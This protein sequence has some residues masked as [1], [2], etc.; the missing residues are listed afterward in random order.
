M[1]ALLIQPPV[2]DT[3][4]YAEWSRRIGRLASDPSCPAIAAAA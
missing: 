1:R 3:Q 2:Y 4:Y